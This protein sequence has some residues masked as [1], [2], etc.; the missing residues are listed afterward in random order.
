MHYKGTPSVGLT[1]DSEMIK[2]NLGTYFSLL[3]YATPGFR[4]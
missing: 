4:V 3:A 1:V 2:F